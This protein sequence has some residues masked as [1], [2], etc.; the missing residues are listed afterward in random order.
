MRLAIVLLLSVWSLFATA[1]TITSISSTILNNNNNNNNNVN[2]SVLLQ[3][4]NPLTSMRSKN[5]G[6]FQITLRRHLNSQLYYA[7]IEVGA[8]RKRLDLL[9][10]LA[11]TDLVIP[12]TLSALPNPLKFQRTLSPTYL[13][14]GDDFSTNYPSESRLAKVF[15]EY[16]L[17]SID[18]NGN[19]ISYTR[20]ALDLSGT[21][22]YGILGLGG[23]STNGNS[24]STVIR[25]GGTDQIVPESLLARLK[26]SGYIRKMAYSIHLGEYLTGTLVFGG[27]D[28]NSFSGSLRYVDML[29]YEDI[30]E[31]DYIGGDFN[32]E[33]AK[34]RKKDRTIGI[35]KRSQHDDEFYS[36]ADIT[37]ILESEDGTEHELQGESFKTY[38]DAPINIQAVPPR[39]QSASKNSVQTQA[40]NQ[41]QIARTLD[42]TNNLFVSLE[43]MS[44]GDVKI[45]ICSRPATINSRIDYTTIPVDVFN[46]LGLHFGNY[47]PDLGEYEVDCKAN[48]GQDFKF[49][50]SGQ[51]ITIKYKNMVTKVPGTEGHERCVLS[52]KPT[53]ETFFTLGTNFL[54]GAYIVVNYEDRT[55]GIAQGKYAYISNMQPI[56]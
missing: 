29:S 13:Q 17:D 25:V 10:D 22:R 43:S 8:F 12:A 21:L 41:A 47:A 38:Q 3:K 51:N 20:M 53:T 45:T 35:Q 54:S 18:L 33:L 26:N 49:T 34:A 14:L 19:D 6:C 11:V 1:S 37:A 31:N 16:G 46:E 52:I 42:Y 5:R 55:L 30:N 15:G 50:F 56:M 24:G 44:V 28:K 9:V 36:E 2:N 39:P 48:N 32:V 7:S 23:G 40:E 4:R 27:V